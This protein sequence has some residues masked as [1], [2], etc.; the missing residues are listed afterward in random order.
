M[1]SGRAVIWLVVAAAGLGVAHLFWKW[2]VE[3]VE[4]PTGRFLV[5]IHRWGR[6]LE[7][8]TILAPDDSYKGVLE[9]VRGPG[10]H[11]LNPLL[12]GHEIHE[13]VDIPAGKCG[14]LTRKF[15][16]RIPPERI[17]AGELLAHAGERG[18]VA[19][20][21]TPGTYSLNPH[22]YDL[23]VVDA[24]EVKAQFV[25]V[26]TRKVGKDPGTLPADK[27]QGSYVVAEDGYRGVQQRYLPPGTYYINPFVEEITPI[28]IRSHKVDFDDISFPSRDGFTLKPHIQVEY[29]VDRELAAELLVRITDEGKIFQGDQSR[30]EIGRNEILQK[31]VLP[32]VRGFARLEGSSFNATDFI[33]VP[34][35]ADVAVINSRERFRQALLEAVKPRC[36][37][38]GIDIRAIAV[39][40]MEPPKELA[41]EIS[42]R[43]SALAEQQR[44]VEMVKQYTN[45]QALK[46]Q[47]A[48]VDQNRERVLAETR[49]AQAETE[50]EQL[51]DVEKLKLTAMVTVATSQLEAAREQA[52]AVKARAEAEAAVINAQNEAEVAALRTSV[53]GFGSPE[54]FARHA[55]LK[56]LA[57]SLG[58]IFA[59]DESE[60]GRLFSTLLVPTTGADTLPRAVAPSPPSPAPRRRHPPIPDLTT[61]S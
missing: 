14:I 11:F 54:L 7:P 40:Q 30:D 22:A 20:P 28:E 2:E 49:L 17:A 27:R 44:N 5:V 21:L 23:K 12:Y 50:A 6:N 36:K 42:D 55:V 18:I 35:E 56:R 8:D 13:M 46:S 9:T 32:H 61:A 60:F 25:G 59:S 26:R 38:L 41:L 43:E 15:G 48:A 1:A 31:V 45:E 29:A 47:E 37:E 33:L 58:E 52:K 16:T 34:G 4:V 19:E 24:V 57:P 53:E 3:R 39:G 51:V 10:R